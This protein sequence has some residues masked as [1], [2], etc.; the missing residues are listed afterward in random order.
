MKRWTVCVLQLRPVLRLVP[1][2]GFLGLLGL[3]VW[4][5]GALATAGLFQSGLPTPVES[6]TPTSMAETPVTPPIGPTLTLTS[7]LTGIPPTS[8]WTVQPEPSAVPLAT[9]TWS[10]TASPEPS[11]G[12]AVTPS[13][14]SGPRYP[15]EQANLRFSWRALIDSIALGVSYIW[16]VCG[17]TLFVLLGLALVWA[18]LRGRRPAE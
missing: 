12:A 3:V 14:G 9:A 2:L 1:W 16:L 8:T 7:P 11:P 13:E 17:I 18:W 6:V 5:P 15:A 10:P 4:R